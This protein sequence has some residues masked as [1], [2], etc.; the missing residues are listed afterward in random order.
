MNGE[1]SPVEA[2]DDISPQELE[3][4]IAGALTSFPDFRLPYEAVVYEDGEVKPEALAKA[5]AAKIKSETLYGESVYEME[6]EGDEDDPDR[7][8]A[9]VR[10]PTEV[11]RG[12]H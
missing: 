7:V 1:E 11:I 10:D 4:H 12:E 8:I 6:V 9:I 5:E 2:L 3:G